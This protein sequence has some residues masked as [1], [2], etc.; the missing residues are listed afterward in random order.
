MVLSIVLSAVICPLFL[1]MEGREAEVLA[2]TTK[3]V[4]TASDAYI[5]TDKI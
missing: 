2:G 1:L 3:T 5:N 4:Y